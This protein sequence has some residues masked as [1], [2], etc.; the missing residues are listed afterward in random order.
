VEHCYR[1]PGRETGV[2]CAN[3][4]R[5]ICHECMVPAA[6]G[7]RCPDCMA[8]QRRGAGRPRVV[9]RQ[10]TRSRWQSSGVMGQAR[11]LSVTKVLIAINVAVFLVEVATGALSSILE[12]VRLGGLVPAYV[13]INHEYW[14]MFTV[15]FLHES[16]FHILFNMVALWFLG[17]Y[18]EAILGHVKFLVLYLVTGLAGSV[19]IVL[20]A[21]PLGVTVGAS[22]AIFGVFGALIAYAFLNRHRDYMAR[23]MFGQL[24]FW[25]ALNVVLGLTEKG[26][27]WQ[28]HV[29]G[30][31]TGIVLMCLYSMFG[32]KSPGGRFTGTDIA[33]TVA[34]IAVLVVLTFWRVQTFTLAA[35]IPWL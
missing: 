5:P 25:L 13:A 10:Q 28:G 11:G 22:G 19:L 16:F 34:V 18:T 1:H 9:T 8:E 27:S 32:R 7:F 31:V 20:L 30:F 23:A 26:L 12:Q 14:R 29:G 4:G 15:M 2:R 17:E 24:M 3:C 21:A 35:L 6:V 33:V